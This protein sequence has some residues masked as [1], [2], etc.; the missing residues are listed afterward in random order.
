VP[1]GRKPL[2]DR[3]WPKVNRG[4]Q[5]ECWEWLA[6]RNPAGY[7]MI[8]S[9][10]DTG[11]PFLAHRVAYELL[12]GSIPEGLQIDHLCRNR[13]CVNPAHMETVTLVE[14]VMRGG[15]ISAQSARK[16]HCKHGHPFAP[17]NF[18]TP[19]SGGRKCLTCSRENCK[20]YKARKREQVVECLE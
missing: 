1:N 7:G 19:P 17:G 6:Y 9:G 13:G 8:G 5:D 3:F 14:N 2:A 10:G 15:G 4:L 16:T 20:R 12:V 18:Y 11:R